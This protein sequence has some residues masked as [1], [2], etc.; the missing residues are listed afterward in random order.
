MKSEP[1]DWPKAVVFDL[2]GTLIDSA[3]DIAHALNRATK[4]RGIEPFPLDQVKE[5]IGGGV[6]QL[7][8]RA[9]RVRGLPGDGLMP[10]VEEFIALYRE[11][12][13][14][15]TTIYEGGRE[16]LAQLHG[17][18]R[19]LGICTNKNHELTVEILQ[20]LDLMKYF[21]SVLGEREGRP[22]K[23]DPAPLLEVV[24]EL[25]ASPQNALMVGD[26]E[27]DV[28]CARAAKMLV[29][30]VDFGYS[31]TAPGALG[32]DAVISRLRELPQFFSSLK[33]QSRST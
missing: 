14:T 30:V 33:P 9:L 12:P 8:G 7:V 32:A 20:Q 21:G 24:A 18:E 26:S 11:N 22:R 2:D 13:T 17:E 28:A 25:G 27:A 3:P 6:P 15:K 19:R 5:M 31:R 1:S 16:L 29:L 10:L 4:R 23:P